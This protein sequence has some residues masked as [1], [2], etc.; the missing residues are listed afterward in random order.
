MKSKN[1]CLLQLSRLLQLRIGNGCVER[2]EERLELHTSAFVS[3]RQAFV[4]IRQYTPEY[5]SV[6]AAYEHHTCSVEHVEGGLKLRHRE[7]KQN[8]INQSIIKL[9]L[10]Q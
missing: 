10:W 6:R 3:I 4:S 1:A 5:I 2:L 7:I 8:E 9:S